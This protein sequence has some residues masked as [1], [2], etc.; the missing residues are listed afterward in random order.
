MTIESIL[1]W[2]VFRGIDIGVTGG[3][4]TGSAHINNCYGEF[5]DHAINGAVATEVVRI[6]DFMSTVATLSDSQTKKPTCSR[7]RSL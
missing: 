4:V 7:M 5:Y 3:S 6:S 2:G 1:F